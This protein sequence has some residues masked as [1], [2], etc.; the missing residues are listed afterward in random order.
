[1]GEE[2]PRDNRGRFA[3]IHGAQ[4]Q[5]FTKRYTDART[6][7]GKRLKAVMDALVDDLCGPGDEDVNS[8]H[9]GLQISGVSL[10][11]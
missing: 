8:L 2:K 6:R 5:H 4:C 10:H 7:E 11:G 1:M 9:W 3:P